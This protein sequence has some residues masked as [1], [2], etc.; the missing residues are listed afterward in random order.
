VPNGY[1]ND[2]WDLEYRR[3]AV[4]KEVAVAKRAE[5]FT[6]IYMCG[7]SGPPTYYTVKA[8]TTTDI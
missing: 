7:N 1:T 3:D 4:R 8:D 6:Y 5:R 2:S